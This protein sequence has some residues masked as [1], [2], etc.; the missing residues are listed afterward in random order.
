[1]ADMV[2]RHDSLRTLFE[3]R[4]GV[5]WQCVLAPYAPIV[6]AHDFAALSPEAR[7]EALARL[8]AGEI[9]APFDLAAAPPLRCHHAD[10]GEA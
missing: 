10:L 4:D 2:E 8:I 3:D 7:E 9:A 5:P 1:M 6:T